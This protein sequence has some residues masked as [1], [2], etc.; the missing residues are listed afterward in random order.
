MKPVKFDK[1][2]LIAAAKKNREPE[3][4]NVT[5]R[6]TKT[7]YKEFHKFCENEGVSHVAILEEFMKSFASK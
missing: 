2:A 5:F 1:K 3:K 6:L 7:V 4:A